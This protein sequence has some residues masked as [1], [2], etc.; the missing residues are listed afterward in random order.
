VYVA[1]GQGGLVTYDAGEPTSPLVA[2]QVATATLG[3]RATSV[4]LSDLL[5]VGTESGVAWL[6]VAE[7]HR[8]VAIAR[9]DLPGSA[10]SIAAAADWLLVVADERLM[11]AVTDAD[12]PAALAFHPEIER[13]QA[14]AAD[15]VTGVA[16]SGSKL[17]VLDLSQGS[18]Y[19]AILRVIELPDPGIAL[20]Y[21]AGQG[22]WVAMK[23]RLL[24]LDVDSGQVIGQLG[25]SGD[26]VRGF[27]VQDDDALAAVGFLGLARIHSTVTLSP[28]ARS[29]YLPR[30]VNTSRFSLR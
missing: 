4:V 26:A 30:A 16:L 23:D 22:A 8:P 3:G 2:N 29:V 19:P 13:A 14:V 6:D 21:G 9:A 27:A 7:P 1:S 12:G 5:Y 24:R 20:G 25:T 11:T 10:T 15:G 17:Y 18:G 28:P